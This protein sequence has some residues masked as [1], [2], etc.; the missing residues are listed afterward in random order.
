MNQQKIAILVD[1][2]CDVPQAVRQAYDMRVLPLKIRYPEGEYDDQVHITAQQVY[3]RFPEE[4]PQTSLPDG[5]TILAALDRARS[6]GYEK[7]LVICISS[8]LSGTYNM[9]RLICREYHELETFVLDTKNISFGSG[10]FALLAARW[11]AEGVDWPTLQRRL[12]ER[13]GDSKVFFCVDTL[14]YLR[15]G[16][17]LGLVAAVVGTALK[18]K[19]IISC[20]ASGVYYMAGKA[21]GRKKGAGSDAGNGG[22]LCRGRAWLA[23]GAS[24]RRRSGR[25][26][27]NEAPPAAAD[28]LL[29]PSCGGA[30]QPGFGGSYRSG[31]AGNCRFETWILTGRRCPVKREID[32][33]LEAIGLPA[34]YGLGIG[35][36]LWLPDVGA[37]SRDVLRPCLFLLVAPKRRRVR[38]PAGPG[39]PRFPW[40]C[41]RR[42]R[43]GLSA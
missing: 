28:R 8:G 24:S 43:C 13:L 40:R 16:G 14:E 3:D 39:G 4:I 9:I 41:R 29:G 21:M 32:I 19:P 35:M 11:I 6:D 31:P 10:V 22:G 27:G 5:K 33:R 17:R 1:S 34:G 20:N 38:E 12:T 42:P 2:G 25:G 15:K 23:G 30:D 26:G 7:A 18:L 36:I 37:V